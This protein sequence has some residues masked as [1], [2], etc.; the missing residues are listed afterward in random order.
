MAEN[1]LEYLQQRSAVDHQHLRRPGT[2]PNG[3]TA[4]P[5]PVAPPMGSV[6]PVIQHPR[7]ESV[8]R[9]FRKDPEAGMFL[10][11]VSPSRPFVFEIGGEKCPE[12]TA[13]LITFYDVAAGRFSGISALDT[14]PVEEERA[15]LVWGFDL[16]IQ[17]MRPRNCT[18][19][20][21]PTP[22]AAGRDQYQKIPGDGR[23]V[24]DSYYR[25]QQSKTFGLASGAGN[26]MLPFRKQRY[27]SPSGPFTIIMLPNQTISMQCTIF[28]PFPFP[29]AYVQFDFAGYALPVTLAEKFIQDINPL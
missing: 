12:H 2:Q 23:A 5:M 16:L 25:A 10:P 15:G 28:R 21:D 20:I 17:N 7:Y 29:L 13:W 19:Q 22:I 8:E 27:G 11:S 18:Y 3:P 26:A 6:Y 1:L 4:S 24:P 9:M 14:V